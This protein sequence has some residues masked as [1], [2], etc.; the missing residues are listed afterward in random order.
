MTGHLEPSSDEDEPAPNDDVPHEGLAI[1]SAPASEEDS[2]TPQVAAV[3]RSDTPLAPLGEPMIVWKTY[4]LTVPLSLYN[5]SDQVRTVLMYK[6]REAK[7]QQTGAKLCV[8][9]R[10]KREVTYAEAYED[11]SF[12]KWYL[13]RLHGPKSSLNPSQTDFATYCIQISTGDWSLG[14]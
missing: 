13:E 10:S 11:K 7:S 9:S 14:A 1:K 2:D 8:F 6:M 5:D 12:R 4:G 3:K